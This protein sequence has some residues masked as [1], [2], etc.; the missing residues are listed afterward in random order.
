MSPLVPPLPGSRNSLSSGLPVSGSGRAGEKPVTMPLEAAWLGLE[1]ITLNE[2]SHREKEK[3]HVM[4]LIRGIYFWKR[5]LT[6][7]L[8]GKGIQKGGGPVAPSALPRGALW[9]FSRGPWTA[10]RKSVV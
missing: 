4:S 9:P 8:N 10:D 1:M 3:Y 6:N 5:I 2:A 7:N